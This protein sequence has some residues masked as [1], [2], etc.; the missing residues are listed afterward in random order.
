MNFTYL[1][2]GIKI[3]GFAIWIIVLHFV[4]L[5][6]CSC[7]SRLQFPS[8]TSSPLRSLFYS[9]SQ[10]L[11]RSSY[12]I[13]SKKLSCFPKSKWIN[14]SFSHFNFWTLETFCLYFYFTVI[15]LVFNFRVCIRLNHVKLPLFNYFWATEHGKFLW[16]NLIL[17]H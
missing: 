12:A 5:C 11:I 10:N 1:F 7:F 17:Q 3:D 9:N 4:I 16:L 15:S 8:A 2:Y 13:C 14:C 6:L